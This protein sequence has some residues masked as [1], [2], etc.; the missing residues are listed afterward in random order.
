MG[1]HDEPK[2]ARRLRELNKNKDMLL[3][4]VGGEVDFEFQFVE[5]HSEVQSGRQN[6]NEVSMPKGAKLIRDVIRDV[7]SDVLFYAES[8]HRDKILTSVAL[9]INAFYLTFANKYPESSGNLHVLAHSLGGVVS[10]DLLCSHFSTAS[11]QIP[12]LECSPRNL[13]ICGS[14]LGLFLSIRGGQEESKSNALSGTDKIRIQT[15][16]RSGCLGTTRCRNIMHPMDALAYRLEP[17]LFECRSPGTETPRQESSGW[18]QQPQDIPYHKGRI[19]THKKIGKMLSFGWRRSATGDAPSA[20][21]ANDCKEVKQ[22]SI[23]GGF[24]QGLRGIF[25]TVRQKGE[26]TDDTAETNLRGEDALLQAEEPSDGCGSEAESAGEPAGGMGLGPCRNGPEVTPEEDS[27]ALRVDF[28]LQRS[29]AESVSDFVTTIRSHRSPPNV[30]VR[31]YAMFLLF[32]ALSFPFLA[33][34]D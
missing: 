15:I 5:W 30:H 22:P 9:Q 2:R 28:K 33:S 19:H 14:P 18:M 3:P 20:A 7:V 17:L 10:Y 13:F 27:S 26:V 34:Y 16:S 1:K 29:A 11:P 6:I 12:N 8:A 31:W 23:S 4:R 32:S 21:E 24:R 25:R